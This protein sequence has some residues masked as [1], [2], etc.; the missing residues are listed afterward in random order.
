MRPNSIQDMIQSS[1]D[2]PSLAHL[3][4]V[5]ALGP[6]LHPLH[7]PEAY[8]Q[9]QRLLTTH[10][11]RSNCLCRQLLHPSTLRSGIAIVARTP[12]DQRPSI[13]IPMLP[14]PID[15][16]LRAHNNNLA[17]ANQHTAP[18]HRGQTMSHFTMT[19][20]WR[21]SG[22]SSGTPSGHEKWLCKSVLLNPLGSFLPS[23]LACFS[24]SLMLS[25]M[26]QYFFF[27]FLVIW[28]AE[29]KISIS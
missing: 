14:R 23:S 9:E 3:D 20:D 5:R 6:L 1:Q 7:L 17:I 22:T 16:C 13:G 19:K 4:Q 10:K 2:H 24:T 27:F 26:V 15:C 21:R 12:V 18:L 25:P 29:C 8:Q 28:T 11:P